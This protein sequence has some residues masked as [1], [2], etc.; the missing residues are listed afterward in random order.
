MK[1]PHLNLREYSINILFFHK[2]VYK[3]IVFTYSY[4]IICIQ[5][6][7]DARYKVHM[8]QMWLFSKENQKHV[9]MHPLMHAIMAALMLNMLRTVQIMISIHDVKLI[10]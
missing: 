5:T 9:L 7:K 4:L 2:M 3:Q 8:P 10:Q 6:V 1:V